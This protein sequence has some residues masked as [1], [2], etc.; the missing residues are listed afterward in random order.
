MEGKKV[1][2]LFENGTLKLP[3]GEKTFAD[4]PW[5]AHAAFDGVEL[6]HIVTSAD[7]GGAFSFHLIR[8]A[9]GKKI[10]EH[11]HDVQ[12]ETHEVICG[13]GTCINGDGEYAVSPGNVTIF[14]PKVPHQVLAGEEGIMVFAK[15]FPALC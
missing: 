10:G 9:P 3:E 11:T 1:Y 14:R 15:F 6:K 7:S 8:V 4:I 12:T 5:T 13:G 2:D